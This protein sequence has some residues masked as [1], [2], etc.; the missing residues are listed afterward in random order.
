MIDQKTRKRIMDYLRLKISCPEDRE[1]L[2]QDI[3]LICCQRQG[4]IDNQEAYIMGICKNKVREYY[5]LRK[6]MQNFIQYF[7]ITSDEQSITLSLDDYFPFLTLEEQLIINHRF[8]YKKSLKEIALELKIN[9]ATLR[10]KFSLLK[11]KLYQITGEKYE[12]E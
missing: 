10:W 5:R 11:K 3:S 2:L 6:K 9:Y 1:D 4:L 8:I 7:L 12:S